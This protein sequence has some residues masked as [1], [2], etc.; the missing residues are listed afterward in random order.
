MMYIPSTRLSFLAV[1]L[2]EGRAGNLREALD[3]VCEDLE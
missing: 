1:R 3:L 2:S